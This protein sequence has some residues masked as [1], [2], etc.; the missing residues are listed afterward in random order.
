[1]YFRVYVHA[2]K[3]S[4][5]SKINE[6]NPGVPNLSENTQHFKILLRNFWL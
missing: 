5:Q 2:K 3:I 1:M 6:L 4:T